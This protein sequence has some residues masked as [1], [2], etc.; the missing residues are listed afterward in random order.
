MFRQFQGEW[1]LIFMT[2]FRFFQSVG[3]F[4][5]LI[6]AN[7]AWHSLIY[8][9]VFFLENCMQRASESKGNLAVKVVRYL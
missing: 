8:C 5:Q 6:L 4:Q 2:C 9:C 7:P 3:H 1:G